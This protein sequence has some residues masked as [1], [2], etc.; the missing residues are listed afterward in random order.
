MRYHYTK[1]TLTI[2]GAFRSL[3]IGGSVRNTSVMEL[4]M[5]DT[6]HLCVLQYDYITVFAAVESPNTI[7]LIV[8]SD[9]GFSDKAFEEAVAVITEAKLQVLCST[10]ITAS[11][12]ITVASEGKVEHTSAGKETELG[13]CIYSSILKGIRE[14]MKENNL[15]HPSYYIYSRYENTGWFEWKKEGCPYYP[16]HGM[17]NQICDFCY[18]PF[19]PCKDESCGT[20]LPSTSSKGGKLWACSNCLLNH[21]PKRAEYLKKHPDCTFEEFKNAYG[22]Y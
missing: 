17:D 7:T 21:D 20:W 18:C 4:E 16:C 9:E 3:C 6:R 15:N 10:K 8:T 1:H 5:E 12:N 2:F 19:Y 14:V 13:K 11:T 22:V